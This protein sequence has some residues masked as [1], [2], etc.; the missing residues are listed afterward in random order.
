MEAARCGRCPS[1]NREDNLIAVAAR[2]VGAD[3]GIR[4]VCFQRIRRARSTSEIRERTKLP[5][6]S[7]V[8]VS[9]GVKRRG[10]ADELEQLDCR[11]RRWS[12]R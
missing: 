9:A 5:L 3:R 6:E 2:E 1:E 7:A 12:Y 11:A 4:R 8:V 10:G